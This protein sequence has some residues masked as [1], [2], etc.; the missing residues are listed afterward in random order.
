MGSNK[1]AN[2]GRIS[3][4]RAFPIYLDFV[5]S[6]ASALPLRGR[7]FRCARIAN[8]SRDIDIEQARC[9]SRLQIP[10]PNAFASL[11]LVVPPRCV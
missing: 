6:L 3:S 8:L 2:F 9:V 4:G 11:R 1:C 5:I 7:A 10:I